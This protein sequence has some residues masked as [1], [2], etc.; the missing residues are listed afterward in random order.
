MEKSPT[1]PV[2]HVTGLHMETADLFQ[3]KLQKPARSVYLP[4]ETSA[5]MVKFQLNSLTGNSPTCD[6]LQCCC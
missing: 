4:Q 3:Q 1:K 5:E 6:V 2:P